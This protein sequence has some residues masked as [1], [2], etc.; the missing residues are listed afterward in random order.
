MSWDES[1][2]F[3]DPKRSLSG[4]I[5]LE[6]RIRCMN[7]LEQTQWEVL[8]QEVELA[9]VEKAL[10][11]LWAD[12]QTRCRA[13]LLNFAIYSEDAAS[14]EHCTELLNDITKQHA[15]RGLLVIADPDVEGSRKV[16]SF[17][18]AHCQVGDGKKSVCSEQVSL[19]VG[20]AT[21]LQIANLIFSNLESDL[22]LFFWWQGDLNENFTPTLYR[23]IDRLF[24][25]SSTWTDAA[26]GFSKVQEA[27][28][29]NAGGFRIY[30][31]SWLRSHQLRTA[32]AASFSDPA[33]LSSLDE[34]HEMEILHSRRGIIS[35]LL[36]TAWIAARL[37]GELCI[38]GKSIRILRKEAKDIAVYLKEEEGPSCV[39]KLTLKSD[40]RSFEISRHE[41]SKF[42]QS[43]VIVGDQEREVLVPTDQLT[44]SELVID[45]LSRLGGNSLYSSIYPLMSQLLA[46]LK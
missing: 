38:E 31:L 19:L 9:S 26:Y 20:D 2:N 12:E 18:T 46:Y 10:K 13:S 7:A 8:G 33:S 5:A 3:S 45:Q 40:D 41:G 25:D 36:L 39:N 44:D 24:V 28:E 34:L 1:P 23:E 6:K 30:D 29:A 11:R 15:C 4:Y 21:T 17:I 42:I 22:P 32:L 35:A 14:I 43:L 27:M 16:R 37:K